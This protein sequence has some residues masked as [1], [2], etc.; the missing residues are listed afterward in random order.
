LCT[1]TTKIILVFTHRYAENLARYVALFGRAALDIVP[2]A[3]IS[4]DIGAV[5]ERVRIA[6]AASPRATIGKAALRPAERDRQVRKVFYV[7]LF[8]SII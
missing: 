2:L 4:E 5:L 1:R 6:I 8:H 3:D 7:S